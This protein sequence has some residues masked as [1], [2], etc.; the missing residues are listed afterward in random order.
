MINDQMRKILDDKQMT[1]AEF[2]R[3]IGITRSAFQ[4]LLTGENNPSEQ[5]IRVICSEFGVN[6]MW[7]T[8][9]E[10]DMYVEPVTDDLMIEE[11]L[12]QRS[13]FIRAAFKAITRT[14]GGW[15]MLEQ[16]AENIQ[17]EVQQ[18]KAAKESQTKKTPAE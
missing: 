9:G 11:A 4:K 17:A 1:Q 13:E 5:T 15:E 14:P 10:G 7:L 12:A 16:L 2:A 3:R 18:Q 6:R 8:D